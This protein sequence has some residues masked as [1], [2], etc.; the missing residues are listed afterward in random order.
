[1]RKITL[2]ALIVCFAGVLVAQEK[3]KRSIGEFSSVSV[4]SGIDLYLTQ[5]SAVELEVEC[6]KDDLHRLRTEVEGK[7]L[8]IYMKGNSS[9][10]WNNKTVP[11]VYLS[12]K[13]LEKLIASG[14]SDIY[15]QNTIDQEYLEVSTS[16]GADIYV[17]VKT[18]EL[19][20]TTSGGSDLKIKGTTDKLTASSSGGSDINARELKAQRVKVTSSGGSDAIVWA[21]K[22]IM[23]NASGGSDIV[24]Y[25]NPEIKQLNESGAGDISHR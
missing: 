24:Y 9:W 11:K 18:T 21:E 23:A 10:N 17:E 25:G 13:Q 20:L 16:G 1:M 4:S 22:E 8:K 5:S 6:R 12:F 19:K 14:G 3:E 2:I 7:T 15:G